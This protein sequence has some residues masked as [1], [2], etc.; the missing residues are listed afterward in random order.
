MMSEKIKVAILGSDTYENTK[1]IKNH[2]YLWK[3]DFGDNLNPATLES[4]DPAFCKNNSPK[5]YF[6]I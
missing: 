3:Q 4:T 2:I 6:I 1:K 5:I